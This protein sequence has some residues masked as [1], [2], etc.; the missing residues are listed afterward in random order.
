MLQIICVYIYIYVY[1]HASLSLYLS[2]SLYS[3]TGGTC[4]QRRSFFDFQIIAAP[5]IGGAKH[6]RAECPAQAPQGAVLGLPLE[7][8]TLLCK[9]PRW[10]LAARKRHNGIIRF[11]VPDFCL[12]VQSR[13]SCGWTRVLEARSFLGWNSNVVRC[14]GLRTRAS[15][16]CLR[17]RLGH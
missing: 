4:L 11:R 15:T 1:V 12:W 10:P 9:V 6:K 3:S 7:A 8:E 13:P 14:Q 2:L 17:H 16:V 5:S